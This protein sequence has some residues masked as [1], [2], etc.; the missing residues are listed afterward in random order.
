[1]L[2][3]AL[4]SAQRSPSSMPKMLGGAGNCEKEGEDQQRDCIQLLAIASRNVEC[5]RFSFLSSE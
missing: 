4:F 1:M 3:K 2:R 5:P